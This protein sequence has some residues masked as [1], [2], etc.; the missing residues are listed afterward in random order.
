MEISNKNRGRGLPNDGRTFNNIV[1]NFPIGQKILYRAM[2]YDYSE[3][4]LFK[5]TVENHKVRCGWPMEAQTIITDEETK[6]RLIIS[7]DTPAEEV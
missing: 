5:A 4:R 3:S 1:Y 2:A 7:G 6:Q